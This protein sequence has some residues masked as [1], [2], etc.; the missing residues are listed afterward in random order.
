MT[1]R[2][3]KSDSEA[4]P[5]GREVSVSCLVS[6]ISEVGKITIICNPR[7]RDTI[8]LTVTFHAGIEIFLSLIHI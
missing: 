4:D 3:R 5:K 8:G 1:R 7:V 2:S 6:R